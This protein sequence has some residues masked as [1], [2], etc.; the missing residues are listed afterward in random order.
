MLPIKLRALHGPQA[1]PLATQLLWQPDAEPEDQA[2]LSGAQP[3][4]G[5]AARLDLLATALLPGSS[6]WLGI[7]G[8]LAPA[9]HPHG[10]T[11]APAQQLPQSGHAEEPAEGDAVALLRQRVSQE[12]PEAVAPQLQAKVQGHGA[13]SLPHSPPAQAEVAGGGAPAEFGYSH[14]DPS[15]IE[16][17]L[18][19]SVALVPVPPLPAPAPLLGSS[20]LGLT[21]PHTEAP[22]PLPAP[23]SA[24][25]AAAVGGSLPSAWHGSLAQGMGPDSLQ[26]GA[27]TQACPDRE[28]LIRYNEGARHVGHEYR[29]HV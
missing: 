29:L 2:A 3:G 15:C 28:Q 18:G 22:A 17:K 27:S 25:S 26:T 23:A 5:S 12:A 13:G 24:P 16:D 1:E 20:A 7:A 10:N 11:S 21:A 6:A 19:M 9:G 4:S 8:I 14:A